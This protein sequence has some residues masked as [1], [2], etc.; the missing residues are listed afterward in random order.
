MMKKR[1][2]KKDKNHPRRAPEELRETGI[3]NVQKT[4]RDHEKNQN[5]PVHLKVQA[6]GSENAVLGYQS[7]LRS[8]NYAEPTG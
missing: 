6:S 4:P 2:E 8:N 1:K 5:P 3:E 7:S